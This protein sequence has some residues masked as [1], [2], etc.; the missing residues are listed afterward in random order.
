MWTGLG[1][2]SQ[3]RKAASAATLLSL[4]CVIS[5]LTLLLIRLAKLTTPFGGIP[6]LFEALAV[7]LITLGPACW[8]SGA[9]FAA[10]SKLYSG[11]KVYFLEC[12]G[13]LAGGLAATFLFVGRFAALPVLSICAAALCLLAWSAWRAHRCGVAALLCVLLAVFSGRIDSASRRLEWRGYS[14]IAQEEGRYGH[15]ALAGMGNLRVL[16]QNG[17]VSSHFPDAAARED[18][19]HWP[20]LACPH[21]RTVLALGV[22][23]LPALPD[24][25]KHPVRLV[26]IV[27]PDAQAAGMLK[28]YLDRKAVRALKDPRVRVFTAD[29]R[30]WVRDHP[31]RYDLILQLSPEPMNASIN[32]LFTR[33]FFQS[34]KASLLPGGMLAFSIPSAE[35]YLSPETAYADA[36]ILRSLSAVF[37]R[38][39]LVP[40][41]RMILLARDRPIDLDPARLAQLYEK[42]GLKNEVLVPSNFPFALMPERREA[43]ERRLSQ[44]AAAANEDLRPMAYFLAWKVWLAKFASPAHFAG[45]A[46]LIIAALWG[47]VKLAGQMRGSLA[48]PEKLAILALGFSG[49]GLEIVLLLLFQIACGALYWRLGLLLAAFMAGLALGSGLAA[50]KEHQAASARIG[51]LAIL[52]FLAALEVVVSS[53]L[54][55]LSQASLST[56]LALF[57]AL[58]G[59]TGLAVGLAFPLACGTDPS[60]VYAADLWGSALGAFLTAAFLVPLA[61]MRLT[62]LLAAAV[63]L[64]P[65]VLL[66]I[67]RPEV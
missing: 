65:A 50:F 30:E 66:L 49:M 2:F 46:A 29:P 3:R 37:K 48:S 54:S 26:E 36:S 13:A 44:V 23:A 22:E 51:L 61:G 39:A 43:V 11:S 58:L 67:K 7:P 34:A 62:V 28:T 55:G 57:P 47:L 59:L 19:V 16:F 40:G 20:L 64:P 12:A 4:F 53:H 1:S 33:E 32:R 21:P 52:A 14:L 41:G 56:A 8:L 27:E 42:R 9:T 35:N 63:L 15:L 5:P 31:A 25:L 24:I 17:V 10:L 18:L 60:V 45:F 38:T 6:G